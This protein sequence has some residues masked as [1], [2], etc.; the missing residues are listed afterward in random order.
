[1]KKLFKKI[2]LTPKQGATTSIAAAVLED[3]DNTT[4]AGG[5]KYLQ[6]YALPGSRSSRRR[7]PY[8]MFEMLGPYVGYRVTT[9]RIP[10]IASGGND[11]GSTAAAAAAAA[12]ALFE[13]CEQLTGCRYPESSSTTTKTVTA[14]D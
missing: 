14:E 9:P 12:K 5:V 7:P 8:P 13:V 4:A 2:Y 3:F 6:P 1:M 10:N 11:D